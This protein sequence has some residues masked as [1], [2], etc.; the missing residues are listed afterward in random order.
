MLEILDTAGTESFTAMRDLYIKN[1]DGFVFVYSIVARNSFN[2]IMQ[3]YKQALRV[4][5]CDTWPAILA[6][7]KVIFKVFFKFIKKIKLF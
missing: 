7:N 6:A 1:G 3:L 2:E 5:D 4:K